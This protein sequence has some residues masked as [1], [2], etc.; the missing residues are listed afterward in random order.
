MPVDTLSDG[1]ASQ[2]PFSVPK[3]RY[4]STTTA[5]IPPKTAISRRIP[6]NA[7]LRQYPALRVNATALTPN[8]DNS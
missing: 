4:P 8:T 7:D 5:Q 3:S 6:L 2:L 1:N